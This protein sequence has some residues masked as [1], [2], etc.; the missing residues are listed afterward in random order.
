MMND[1]CGVMSERRKKAEEDPPGCGAVQ[2]G[3]IGNRQADA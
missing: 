3:E 1:E 2:P